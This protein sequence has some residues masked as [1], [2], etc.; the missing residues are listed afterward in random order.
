MPQDKRLGSNNRKMTGQS[1][2][3]GNGPSGCCFETA[4]VNSRRRIPYSMGS[5]IL[6]I[7]PPDSYHA[8]LDDRDE[9]CL[10]VDILDLCHV[11]SFN[12]MLME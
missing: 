12:S 8:K 5:D 11:C 7:V 3:G 9:R 4:L 1:N 10:S 6:A 2:S